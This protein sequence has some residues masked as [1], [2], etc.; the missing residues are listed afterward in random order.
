[1]N[2]NPSQVQ[3]SHPIVVI[4]LERFL[5]SGERISKFLGAD[6]VL[7]HEDVFEVVFSKYR[8]LI[9]VMSSGIAIRKVAPF[10]SDKWHDPALVIVTPDLK[11]AI[12]VLG[13]HHGA[14]EVAERLEELGIISVISTATETKG[15]FS[16]ERVAQM[17][18][19]SIVNRDS[20][21]AVNGAILDGTLMRERRDGYRDGIGDV[22]G[23]VMGDDSIGCAEKDA[24]SSL[25]PLIHVHPPAIVL[26][27]SQVSVLVTASPY[28]MGIGC[29]RGTSKEEIEEAIDAGCRQ[30]KIPAS[31]ITTYAT[32]VQ[33][34]HETGLHEAVRSRGSLIFLDDK[35]MN[36]E[37][38]RVV[39]S[40]QARR[41]GLCG[42]S[43]PACLALST[44]GELVL[45]KQVYGRVTIA[46]SR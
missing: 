28:I 24:S 26:A 13:G 34:L 9:A 2:P 11:Y 16:V 38:A 14:N 22:M 19:A 5:E 29:K 4:A 45:E 7:Y 27:T 3:A 43:E 17:H 31:T 23:D 12:P 36:A 44:Y 40:S 15:L 46:I 21:R 18:D 42:V 20:T 35:T 39:S 8:I 6:L 32:T 30:A 1:M 33:K 10:L 25:P 41:L 37:Q